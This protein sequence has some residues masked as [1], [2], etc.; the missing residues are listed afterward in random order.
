M[1]PARK[2]SATLK[3]L[4]GQRVC[5]DEVMP[6]AK[7][8]ARSPLFSDPDSDEDAADVPTPR[9]SNM[10]TRHMWA[11]KSSGSSR[12]ISKLIK[13]TLQ[14]GVQY[15]IVDIEEVNSL[16][17]PRQIWTVK[18]LGDTSIKVFSCADL[19]HFTT[20]DDGYLDLKRRDEM[21]EQVRI[22]YKGLQGPQD[23]V[24]KICFDFLQK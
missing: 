22:E 13:D 15:D 2:P 7:K 5:G 18:D 17:G 1:G 19:Q 8:R 11:V 16:Y 14:V 9:T 24:F 4:G 10:I 23:G 12:D 21:I 3:K 20:D 6:P